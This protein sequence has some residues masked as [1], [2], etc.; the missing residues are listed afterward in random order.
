MRDKYLE[1]KRFPET[2]LEQLVSGRAADAG[3]AAWQDL[4]DAEGFATAERLADGRLAR[5]ELARDARLDDPGVGRVTARH[6]VLEQAVLDLLGQ[7]AALDRAVVGHR[8]SSCPRA[9][10]V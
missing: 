9:R 10:T 3:A 4:D 7:D 8:P 2:R 6:D 5:A 1:V